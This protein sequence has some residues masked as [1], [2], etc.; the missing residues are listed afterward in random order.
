MKKNI[1][2]CENMVDSNKKRI[3]I[4]ATGGT[5]AGL[6]DSPVDF[7]G[8]TAGAAGIERLLQRIPEIN[9]LAELQAEDFCGIAS[10]NGNP[11]LWLRI[12][13]RVDELLAAADVDGLVITAGT[14][15]LEELAYFLNLLLKTAKPVVLVGAMRPLSAYGTDGPVNLYNAVAVAAA[16]ESCGKGVL[17]VMNDT[18]LSARGVTK[19]DSFRVHT[20]GGGDFGALGFVVAGDVH[21][22]AA[23]YAKHTANT[24]LFLADIAALPSVEIF[25]MSGGAN[26]RLLAAMADLGARGVVVAGFGNGSYSDAVGEE[27]AGLI[28][29][30]VTCV[31]CSRTYTGFAKSTLPGLIAGSDL[32][33]QKARVLLLVALACGKSTADI[34]RYFKEY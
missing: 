15:T 2:V 10:E 6:A 29:A 3:H 25:Y 18:I 11:E 12:A 22:A 31:V 1:K 28:A 30:G 26:A 5:I 9:K 34:E 23:P 27:L 19:Q 32:S 7:L 17:V 20:F 16:P 8:Y 4:L 21:F 13:R 33:P 14:D 24:E